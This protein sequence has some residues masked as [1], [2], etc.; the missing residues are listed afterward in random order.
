VTDAEAVEAVRRGERVAG[1]YSLHAAEKGPPCPGFNCHWR[2][3]FCDSETDVVEC[4]RC[5]RQEL[6]RC[7]FD[8]EYA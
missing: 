7:N 3:L 5:G 2:T 8:E 6:K 1:T 4:S